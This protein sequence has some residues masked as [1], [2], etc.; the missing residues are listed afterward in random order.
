MLLIS[1][2]KRLSGDT[3]AAQSL[4]LKASE[5]LGL[6]SYL[7]F[8]LPDSDSSDENLLVKEIS[9]L[10]LSPPPL[11]PHLLRKHHFL[12]ISILH[13]CAQQLL[14]QYPSKASSIL[15]HASTFLQSSTSPA[16]SIQNA[17][18]RAEL[19]LSQQQPSQ[20]MAVCER[21]ATG[22]NSQ[23]P[24]VDPLLRMRYAELYFTLGRAA[25]MN[26]SLFRPN[27]SSSI[28]EGVGGMGE[29]Q[30]EEEKEVILPKRVS[31]RCTRRLNLS[32]DDEAESRVKGRG[33]GRGKRTSQPKPEAKQKTTSITSSSLPVPPLLH[34][35]L[36]NLL[37]SH[38]TLSSIVLFCSPPRSFTITDC[39]LGFLGSYH[40]LP[41]PSSLFPPHTYTPNHS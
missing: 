37:T 14:S 21:A 3:S 2:A 19:L 41:L 10:T 18:L 27:L 25:L 17:Q 29:D 22:F 31:R 12:A 32:S 4:L 38:P 6:K 7:L 28:W 20:A 1:E 30:D 40:C 15:E 39:V 24:I 5:L 33:R 34:P 23:Q 26:V 9:Q 36:L 11:L 16:L 35:V 13:S 8:F